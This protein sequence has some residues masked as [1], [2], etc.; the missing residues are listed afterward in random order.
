MRQ[1]AHVKR[2]RAAL[3]RFV[4]NRNGIAAVEFAFIL[5]IMLTIYFGLVEVGQGVMADRKV[6]ALNR[7]LADLAG[8]ATAIANSDMSNIFDAATTVMLPFTDSAPAMSIVHVVIDD[9][10]TA[11]VCWSDQRNSTAPARGSAVTVPADLL[12]PN[13]SLIMSNA[14]YTYTPT[15]G[16]VITGPIT[17]TSNTI[18]MRPRAGKSGG[19]LNI[20]QIERIG[21]AMCTPYS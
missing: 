8:Q 14:S 20:E 17:L 5:P 21:L 10:S 16:Y 19:L 9:K 6:T 2:M 12:I 15:L 1:P 3:R 11:R 4:E 18:Y 7:A 13:S